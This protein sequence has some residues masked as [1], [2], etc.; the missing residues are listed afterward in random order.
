MDPNT[1]P[2]GEGRKLATTA[3]DAPS[4]AFDLPGMNPVEL[5]VE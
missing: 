3:N 1:A 2:R 4:A 5:A